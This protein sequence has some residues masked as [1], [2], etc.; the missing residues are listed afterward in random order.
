MILS[1]APKPDTPADRLARAARASWLAPAIVVSLN[2]FA[3]SATQRVPSL[4]MAVAVLQF[5]LLLGGLAMGLYVLLGA[6]KIAD[7]S[8][9]VAPALIGTALCIGILVLNVLV[10]T[11]RIKPPTPPAAAPATAPTSSPASSAPTTAA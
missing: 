4:G 5:V 6:R 9:V 8:R 2:C 7:G 1:D 3:N 10:L 11:G